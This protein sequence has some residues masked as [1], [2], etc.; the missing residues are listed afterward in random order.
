[1]LKKSKESLLCA[2]QP[3]TDRVLYETETEGSHSLPCYVRVSGAQTVRCE[4]YSRL[5]LSIGLCAMTAS[6]E[7]MSIPKMD[8]SSRGQD[9]DL[10]LGQKRCWL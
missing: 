8:V 1:M 10:L 4:T 3:E 5:W 2:S 9:K 6:A 7:G